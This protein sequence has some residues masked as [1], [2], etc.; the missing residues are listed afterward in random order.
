MLWEG[1]VCNF[2]VSK[3]QHKFNAHRG[4]GD[5]VLNPLKRGIGALD[6]CTMENDILHA[7]LDPLLIKIYYSRC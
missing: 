6:V 7:I 3:L 2:D 1:R 4:I 5:E